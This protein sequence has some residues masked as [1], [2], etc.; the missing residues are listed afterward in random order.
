[1]IDFTPAQNLEPQHFCFLFFSPL[2]GVWLE[3]PEIKATQTGLLANTFNPTIRQVASQLVVMGVMVAIATSLVAFGPHFH[4]SSWL[5][6]GSRLGLK[7]PKGTRPGIWFVSSVNSLRGL[8]HVS[9][10][11]LSLTDEHKALPLKVVPEILPIMQTTI[12]TI[13][14]IKSK[15]VKNAL[16]SSLARSTFLAMVINMSSR[17]IF[18]LCFA[19]NKAQPLLE[20]AKRTWLKPLPLLL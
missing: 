7:L 1:M 17:G 15:V 5:P 14:L 20:P 19:L 12:L 10:P 18:V 8:I 3:S 16:D 6:R 2:L 9:I 4:F 11:L 13:E